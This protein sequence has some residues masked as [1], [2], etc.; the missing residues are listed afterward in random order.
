MSNPR[1]IGT[2]VG[3]VIHEAGARTKYG[4]FF[5]TL[6]THYPVVDVHD[7]TLRGPDRWLNALLM[8][9]P[10]RHQWRER[11]YKNIP[12]FKKR[13]Q[14]TSA[15][16]DS[17]ADQANLVLQVGT[18]FHT[19]TDLPV[20][21]YTD[22]T[23]QLSAQK[24]T[25]GRSP[26]TPAQRKQWISLEQQALSQ[27]AHIFTRGAFV[28]ESLITDYGISPERV[29]A[30]GG[31]VNFTELPRHHPPPR[32]PTNR[33]IHRQRAL[34]QRW[35]LIVNRLCPSTPTMPRCP[36]HYAN[37]GEYPRSSSS[38]WG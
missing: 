27:A 10:N 17:L 4:L 3:D 36:S 24:P 5:D 37:R 6:R 12:A 38:R 14:R 15:V 1:I 29:T 13:S 31:G 22:Y 8:F 21:I 35:R 26:F 25:A 11:F 7:A 18:L 32:H 33:P 23:A 19:K 20:I 9:H 34:S 2:L 30:V 28:K 16:V